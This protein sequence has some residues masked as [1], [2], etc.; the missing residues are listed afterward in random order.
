MPPVQLVNLSNKDTYCFKQE[1]DVSSRSTGA[2]LALLGRG[3]AG[4]PLGTGD[5]LSQILHRVA[6]ISPVQGLRNPLLPLEGLQVLSDEVEDLLRKGALVSTPLD[7]EEWVLQH[8]FPSTPK[9][10]AIADSS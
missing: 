8:L 4:R 3:H 5:N 10:M 2:L 7:Y 6:L 1:R 9:R